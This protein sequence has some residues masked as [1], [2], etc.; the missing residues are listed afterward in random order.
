[1]PYY[2]ALYVTDVEHNRGQVHADGAHEYAYVAR[3]PAGAAKVESVQVE[4]VRLTAPFVE[5]VG[6]TVD[7]G[8][9]VHIPE[10]GPGG[11]VA[12]SLGGQGRHAAGARRSGLAE[13]PRISRLRGRRSVRAELQSPSCLQVHVQHSA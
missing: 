5:P 12:G 4:R 6:V 3:S 9:N 1:M 8:G 13:H 7:A 11:F 2:Q 10:H